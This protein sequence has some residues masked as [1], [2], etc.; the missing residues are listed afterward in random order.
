M[1]GY[2]EPDVHRELTRVVAGENV[3][4]V[5]FDFRPITIGDV[6][7][8]LDPSLFSTSLL[9]FQYRVQ[10][11]VAGGELPAIDKIETPANV[12]EVPN[13]RRSSG[14]Q[15]VAFV[16]SAVL[17]P[18]IGIVLLEER[19]EFFSGNRAGVVVQGTVF[20]LLPDIL[21]ERIHPSRGGNS[22]S[23]G[24]SIAEQF[25]LILFARGCESRFSGSKDS[26]IAER[27]S[28]PHNQ[29]WALALPAVVG[30]TTKIYACFLGNKGSPCSP[31]SSLPIGEGFM[32]PDTR[33]NVVLQDVHVLVCCHTK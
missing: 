30:Y 14:D 25:L 20:G 24:Y 19:G 9:L 8:V 29:N 4:E 1:A 28:Q 22:S 13:E 6:L 33:T 11:F 10:H 26:A 23:L 2:Q 16:L 15:T 32:S 3:I 7:L 21:V 27:K 17:L 5:F 12:A 18:D 31:K